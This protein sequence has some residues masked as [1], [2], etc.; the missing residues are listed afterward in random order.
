MKKRRI[1]ILKNY[2]NDKNLDVYKIEGKRI[3]LNKW[4]GDKYYDCFELAENLIDIVSEKKFEVKPIY[5]E[6]VEEEFEIIDFKIL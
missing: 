6:V 3:V 4:D 1:K 5:K 2:W